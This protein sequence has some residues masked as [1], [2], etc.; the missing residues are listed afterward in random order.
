[1][2]APL[3]WIRVPTLVKEL[4]RRDDVHVQAC[5]WPKPYSSCVSL[6]IH[7]KGWATNVQHFKKRCF[8]K[9]NDGTGPENIQA[10]VEK[11]IFPGQKINAG[12]ALKLMGDWLPSGGWL[13][14]LDP[15]S[16]SWHVT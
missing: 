2:K 1:M 4:L 16:N 11:D 12:T 5:H 14:H 13:L 8:L 7:L 9:I 6:T 15:S 3:K 10:V